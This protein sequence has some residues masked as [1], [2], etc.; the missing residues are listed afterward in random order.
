MHSIKMSIICK[1]L[2]EFSQAFETEC[3]AYP[4]GY[5]F[6]EKKLYYIEG[7]AHKQDWYAYISDTLLQ[8][9]D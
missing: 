1:N 8:D 7:L 9:S 2:S 3:D 6:F 4:L 5:I